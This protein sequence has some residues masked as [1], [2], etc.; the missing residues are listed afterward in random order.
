MGFNQ[1][2]EEALQIRKKRL[3]YQAWHCG[4]RELDLILGAFADCH[5]SALSPADMDALEALFHVPAATLYRWL[6]GQ[7]V[8]PPD[9][10][11]PVIHRVISST[12]RLQGK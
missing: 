12:A 10:D 1:P 9:H 3:R 11:T 8:V 2:V 7:E 5:A 4:M 6:A